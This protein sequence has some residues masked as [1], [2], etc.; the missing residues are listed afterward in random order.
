MPSG[1]AAVIHDAIFRIWIFSD[2]GRHAWGNNNAI[3]KRA[4][5]LAFLATL[6]IAAATVATANCH[7]CLI[8]I[9][10]FAAVTS[11][12][13]GLMRTRVNLSLS[14]NGY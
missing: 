13:K 6:L 8:C 10:L 11:I 3:A 12:T 1:F 2:E 9:V 14:Q 7:K 4:R 5:I